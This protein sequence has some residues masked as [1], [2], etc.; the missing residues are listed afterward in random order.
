METRP[1]PYAV[2]ASEA[3]PVILHFEHHGLRQIAQA[4]RRPVGLRMPGDIVQRLLH[5]AV[6]MD[7]DAA[8]QFAAGARLLILHLDAVCFS[9]PGRY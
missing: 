3:R 1:M 5:H 9:K 2:R 4:H 8:V 7:R 6:E